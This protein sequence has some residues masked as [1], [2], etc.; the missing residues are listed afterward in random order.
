MRRAVALSLL[1][2]MLL[3]LGL[4]CP[5]PTDSPSAAMADDHSCC[6]KEGL[7]AAS[8]CCL[9]TADASRPAALDA[10][11]APAAPPA[12]VSALAPTVALPALIRATAP[13]VSPSPPAVL[14]I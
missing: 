1:V 3:T 9:T 6:G 11:A 12:L 13:S 4:V 2:A 5:C 8:S 10:A 7:R 14:R